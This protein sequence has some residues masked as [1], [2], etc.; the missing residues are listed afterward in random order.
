MF[1]LPIAILAVMLYSTPVD[2]SSPKTVEVKG[3]VVKQVVL[4][5]RSGRKKKCQ[6]VIDKKTKKEYTVCK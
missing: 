3:K 4:K 1:Y 2:A 5:D 6:I